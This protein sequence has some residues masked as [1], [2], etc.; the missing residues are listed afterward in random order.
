M[1]SQVVVPGQAAAVQP[2]AEI[3]PAGRPRLL[4]LDNLRIVLIT[5][6]V[7]GHVAASYG[8]FGDWSYKEGEAN[9]IIFAI[10]AL[11]V[12]VGQAFLLGLF[13][14]IAA[15][16]TPRA[17]DRK[18]VWAFVADRLKRLGIPLLIFVFVINPFD[19]FL[20]ESHGG[21]RGS[22]GQLL[23]QEGWDSVFDPGPMW[24]AEALL[25]F[26]L[27]YAAWRLLAARRGRSP[28]A[29]AVQAP[30]KAPG[31][32]AIALFALGL[33]LLT[34]LVRTRIPVGA[35]W[36]PLHLQ[37]AHFVQYIGLFVVGPHGLSWE[38]AGRIGRCPRPTS[39]VGLRWCWC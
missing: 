17:C 4:Y 15:Y 12:A 32:V 6:V 8:A 2:T 13:F 7:V 5:M 9:P 25:I 35:S 21:F 34:F 23:A 28:H 20:V 11:F 30:G 14:L 33:G 19:V 38:L 36:E 26:S 10:T 16:L 24:F 29:Y 27:V 3:H 18:G 31:N 22:F 37:L 39:G 1:S